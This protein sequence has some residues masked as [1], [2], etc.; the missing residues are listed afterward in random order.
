[1]HTKFLPVRGHGGLARRLVTTS[2]LSEKQLKDKHIVTKDVPLLVINVNK[3]KD[4]FFVNLSREEP[5]PNYVHFG[6]WT[7]NWVYRELVSE[8]RGSDGVYTLKKQ[9]T[10]NEALDLYIY[11]RAILE[12]KGYFRINWESPPYWCKP[13]KGPGKKSE[14]NKQVVNP[15]IDTGR[16]NRRGRR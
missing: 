4:E 14:D 16:F 10:N 5:G 1:L 12:K 15:R 3:L 13:R 7:P 8:S 9:K 6:D 2:T 11:A